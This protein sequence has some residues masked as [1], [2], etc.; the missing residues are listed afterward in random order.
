MQVKELYRYGLN[1]ATAGTYLYLYA[2][3]LVVVALS[4]K[5]G[6]EGFGFTLEYYKALLSA[7]ALT[8][9][10]LLSVKIA[11][12][13]MVI[14]TILSIMASFGI[15]R[16]TWPKRKSFAM[17]YLSLPLML[18]VIV[19]AIGLFAVLSNLGLQRGE[20]AIIIGHIVYALPFA[21][22]VMVSGLQD[23]DTS[24]EEAAMDLGGDELT[25]MREVTLPLLAPSI[26][27]AALF[28]FTLSFDEFLIAFFVGGLGDTTLPMEI[29]S[30][31]RRGITP[32][33]YSISVV[34]L[35][36]SISIAA[37]ATR[38]ERS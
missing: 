30:R 20:G 23:F 38:L 7:Q 15:V 28:S 26:I 9:A 34:V 29:W 14:T 3:I 11:L 33:I 35:V 18:P 10:L 27:A 13:V 6:G 5:K 36:I 19:Y 1:A 8:S 4:F 25:I 32:E 12:V 22:L 24:L 17:A 37:L 21:T 31:V 2:P 16:Y